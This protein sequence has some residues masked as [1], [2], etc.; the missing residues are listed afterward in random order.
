MLR[1]AGATEVHMRVSSPPT[2][3]PC[4]YGI[5]TPRRKELIAANHGTE[6]IREFIGAN[7]LGYLSLEGMLRAFGRGEDATCA[8]CFSGRYPVAFEEKEDQHELFDLTDTETD[9]EE[10]AQESVLERVR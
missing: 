6:A 10:P 3:S 5:D 8:A 7:S 4:R 2:T 1:A 9:V